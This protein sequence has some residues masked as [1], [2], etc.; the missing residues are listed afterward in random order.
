MDQLESPPRVDAL[1]RIAFLIRILSASFTM[2]TAPC[3]EDVVAEWLSRMTRTSLI[4]FLR[5]RKFESCQRRERSFCP[6]CFPKPPVNTMKGVR[7]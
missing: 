7:G 3:I 1:D 6:F 2:I 5:E 4:I